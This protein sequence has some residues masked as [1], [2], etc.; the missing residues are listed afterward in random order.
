M[1]AF[2]RPVVPSLLSYVAGLIFYA[3]H[4]PE[5]YLS[6]RWAHSH[7]LDRV[8]GGSHAIWHVFIVLAISLHKDAMAHLKGGIGEACYY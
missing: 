6:S 8:G 5:C 4:F 3:T 1:F 7:I 2:I